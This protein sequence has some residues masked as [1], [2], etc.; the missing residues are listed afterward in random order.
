MKTIKIEHYWEEVI[1]KKYAVVV[2][3]DN[4]VIIESE[5]IHEQEVETVESG[6]IET[7]SLENAEKELGLLYPDAKCVINKFK[8]YYDN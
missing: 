3:D 1:I 6:N 7:I 4:D 5:V 2:V 8:K